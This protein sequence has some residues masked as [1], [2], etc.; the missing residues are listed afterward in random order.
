MSLRKSSF[1][2]LVG[3]NRF[4]RPFST[5]KRPCDAPQLGINQFKKMVHRR[6][7]PRLPLAEKHRDLACLGHNK[8]RFPGDLPGTF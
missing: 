8:L 6:R 7:A 5:E 1:T 2:T 4:F 3:C